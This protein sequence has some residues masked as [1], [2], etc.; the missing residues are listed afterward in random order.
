MPK[1]PYITTKSKRLEK[2]TRNEQADLTFDLIN[3]FS[4]V[5]NPLSTSLLLQDLLT[6]LEI[7]N[8]SK[9]LRI[10]KFL[11]AGK[12]QDKN[13]RVRFKARLTRRLRAARRRACPRPS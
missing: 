3:A 1:F 5:K 10:A 2:L 11:L 12:K 4:L 13:G 9:R 8:L 7:K 6:A